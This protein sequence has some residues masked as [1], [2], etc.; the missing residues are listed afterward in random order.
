MHIRKK[1]AQSVSYNVFWGS[2][3]WKGAQSNGSCYTVEVA[4]VN[5]AVN[6]CDDGGEILINTFVHKIQVN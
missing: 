3:K 5:L 6:H 1:P 2:H 4:K